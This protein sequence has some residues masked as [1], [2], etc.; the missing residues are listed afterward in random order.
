[1]NDNSAIVLFVLALIITVIWLAVKLYRANKLNKKHAQ[2]HDELTIQKNKLHQE[3]AQLM[4]D[5]ALLEAEHLKFQLQPHTLGNVVM[6]IN[7]VA[8]NLHKGTEAL[9]ESLNYILYKGNQHLVSVS[10]ELNFIRKY[11]ELNQLLYADSIATKVDDSQIQRDSTYFNIACIPHLITAY[12]IENAF[13]HGDITHPDFL[14]IS[15]SLSDNT[16]V[17]DVINKINTKAKSPNGNS[18][19]GI[20]NMEKRLELLLTNRY[21]IKRSCIDQEYQSTLTIHFS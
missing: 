14:K 4:A 21:E 2:Q 6:T 16:F 10:D 12:L 20:R 18:G 5:N 9:A 8:K 11:L 13:K 17:F 1:M 15:M 19:L 7:T 3:N